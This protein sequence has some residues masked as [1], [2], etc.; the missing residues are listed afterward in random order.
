MRLLPPE[1]EPHLAPILSLRELPWVACPPSE[2]HEIPK[3]VAF[4]TGVD[5]FQCGLPTSGGFLLLPLEP[6]AR[7]Y[8]SKD[9][10]AD[11]RSFKCSLG[12]VVYQYLGF[13]DIK[14]AYY[15]VES[16]VHG[17]AATLERH[18]LFLESGSTPERQTAVSLLLQSEFELLFVTLRALF[19]QLQFLLRVFVKRFRG[20]DLPRSFAKMVGKSADELARDYSLASLE[21]EWIQ[22]N[23]D[24]FRL[25]RTTRVNIEHHGHTGPF[26]H[27]SPGG[28]AVDT[29]G[30]PWSEMPI[31]DGVVLGPMQTGPYFRGI[32]YLIS[33]G[34][35]TVRGLGRALQLAPD[36]PGDKLTTW[37][38][39][40]LSPFM[41]HFHQLWAY[42]NAMWNHNS[43]NSEEWMKGIQLDPS[44]AP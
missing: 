39:Y 29:T 8:L 19:D 7:G 2:E 10:A 34:V 28:L 5:G 15:K 1:R 26:V 27:F 42:R 37:E 30:H 13:A 22:G 21:I 33:E 16:D 32:A 17:L 23:E 9:G 43:A 4:W 20:K 31:W 14:E 24:F 3:G 35:R 38:Y 44:R 18:R 12:T 6:V 25:V 11:D 36:L 40:L 41:R